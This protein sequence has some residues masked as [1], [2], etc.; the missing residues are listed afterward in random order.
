MTGSSPRDPRDLPV[1][2]ALEA[3]APGHIPGGEDAPTMPDVGSDVSPDAQRRH[4]WAS[5]AAPPAPGR[6]T[7]QTTGKCFACLQAG[8]ERGVVLE[9]HLRLPRRATTIS[10]AF[11]KECLEQGRPRVVKAYL[12]LGFEVELGRVSTMMGDI[13]GGESDC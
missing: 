2:A 11:H 4:E 3:A 6:S 9:V 12:D 7:L 5:A 13:C 10:V 8:V 1:W